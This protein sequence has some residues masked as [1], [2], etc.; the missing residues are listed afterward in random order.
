[1]EI[2]PGLTAE[3]RYLVRAADLADT[4]GTHLPR[5]LSTPTLICWMEAICHETIAGLLANGQTSVGASVNIRHMAAT[6]E[7]F[8]VRVRGELLE[9]SGRKLKFKVEAWDEVEKIG[10]GEH[11]RVLIDRARFDQR[12]EDKRQKKV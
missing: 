2:H 8:E 5:V 4:Y 11:E 1:M 3:T 9:V 12:L 6:P 7:H 10:E